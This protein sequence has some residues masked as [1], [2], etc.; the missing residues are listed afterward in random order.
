MGFG[1]LE[2]A[3]TRKGSTLEEFFQSKGSRVQA[4]ESLRGE[5]R[6]PEKG[7]KEPK[8]AWK[9]ENGQKEPKEESSGGEESQKE[10]RQGQRPG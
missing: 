9:G 8:E 1:T 4:T 2:K 5:A 10:A 6:E 7:Q 3:T